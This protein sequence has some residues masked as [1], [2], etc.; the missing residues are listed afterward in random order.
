MAKRSRR[1]ISR[2]EKNQSG[3]IWNLISIFDFRHVRSTQ[4]LLP[5]RKHVSKRVIGD[6]YKLDKLKVYSEF[7]KDSNVGELSVKGIS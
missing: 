7:C 6:A 2:Y 4:K 3:C 1:R 5:D